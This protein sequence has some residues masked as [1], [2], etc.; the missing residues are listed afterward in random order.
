MRERVEAMKEIWA[1]DEMI[2][3]MSAL[4]RLAAEAGRAPI[5]VTLNGAPPD[6]ARMARYAA[7]GVTRAVFLLRPGGTRD[8]ILS[9]LEDRAAFVTDYDG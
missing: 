3:Q 4:Q 1:H 8:E 6:K 7:A 5:P 9:V 2:G